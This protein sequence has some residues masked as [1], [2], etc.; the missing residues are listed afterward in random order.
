MAVPQL[1]LSQQHESLLGELVGV[2]KEI[3]VSGRC[4]LGPRVEAFEQDL[5][6]FC[7]VDQVVGVSSGTD[8][9]LMTLMALGIGQ[10]DEVITSPFTFFATAGSIARAGATPVFVDIDPGTFNINAGGIEQ[11]LTPRTRAIMPVHLYGQ[12]ADMGRVM[13]VAR[14]RGLKVIEDAAQAIG[15]KEGGQP[16]GSIGDVGCL[17]FYP[18]KNLSAMGDAGAC[19]TND[20]ELARVLRAYRLHGEDSKY[21]HAY[22]GGNFRI[23][24]LQGAILQ[25]KL[26]HLDSWIEKRRVIAK[27]YHEALSG[28]DLVLPIEAKG[29]HHVYN[30]YTI[31]VAGDQRDA[32]QEHLKAKGIGHDVYYPYPLHLQPCFEYLGV[33]RGALP[34]AERAAKEV[35]SLPIYPEM[36]AKMQDEVVQAVSGYYQ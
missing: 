17:S 33:K 3:A 11:A 26:R 12:S 29:K 6:R 27:R 7:G 9:L 16:V 22:I 20:Q 24:A 28:F 34:Q 4:V 23:D 35:L 18:T 25:I 14:S 2:F 30:Q 10:G 1:D 15:A 36:S 31:R 5:G 19:T 8:A 32:L 13:E 21:H